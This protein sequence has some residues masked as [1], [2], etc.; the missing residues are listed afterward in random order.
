MMEEIREYIYYAEG[1]VFWSILAGRP[2]ASEWMKQGVRLYPEHFREMLMVQTRTMNTEPT[3]EERY[4]RLGR[5]IA[6]CKKLG[7]QN[8]Y[9]WDG[10][11]RADERWQKLHPHAVPPITAFSGKEYIDENKHLDRLIDAPTIPQ[12]DGN[13]G[14]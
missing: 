1:N 3:R 14:F 11:Y 13:W 9:S 4:K 8:T 12:D 7:I 10:L 6:H 5:L 2:G